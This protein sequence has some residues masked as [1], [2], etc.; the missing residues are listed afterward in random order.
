MH[1]ESNTIELGEARLILVSDGT[2][3]MDGGAVFGLEPRTLWQEVLALGVE[4][5]AAA[6]WT[7]AGT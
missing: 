5:L 4:P 1:I 3:W 6:G 7:L 2:C